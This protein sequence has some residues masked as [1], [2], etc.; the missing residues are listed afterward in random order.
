M[1]ANLYTSRANI[2][3]KVIC[4]RRRG[5][6]GRGRHK[7]SNQM[8]E[9]NEQVF[10]L[11]LPVVVLCE[12]ISFRPCG[13]PCASRYAL[14]PAL[15]TSGVKLLRDGPTTATINSSCTAV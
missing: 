2:Y 8:T 3:H 15:H 7:K 14:P 11:F 10:M 9:N 5:K 12:Y 4:I 6:M 13:T 1:I